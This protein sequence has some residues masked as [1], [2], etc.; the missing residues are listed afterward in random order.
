M[1]STVSPHFVVPVGF[2]FKFH[3]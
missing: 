3:F 2:Y 1:I